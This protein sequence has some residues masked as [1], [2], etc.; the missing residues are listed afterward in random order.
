MLVTAVLATQLNITAVRFPDAI[1]VCV[2]LDE[3][4]AGVRGGNETR[5]S[6]VSHGGIVSRVRTIM[7]AL[8]PLTR[9]SGLYGV[10]VATGQFGV[11][12]GAA[13]GNPEIPSCV[14][15]ETITG[16]PLADSASWFCSGG[17]L[18]AYS[19]LLYV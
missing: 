5:Y 16:A 4:S 18:C 7:R 6:S 9:V 2:N 14:T 12:E 3:G 19:P 10:G 17:G 11:G 13:C 15:P 1:M 8:S